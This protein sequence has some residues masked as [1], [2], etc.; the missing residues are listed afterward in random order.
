MPRSVVAN[1]G[2]LAQ[3]NADSCDLDKG[4]LAK[5]CSTRGVAHFFG[6]IFHMPDYKIVALGVVERRE[7]PGVPEGDEV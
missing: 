3:C 2:V 1:D 4:T 6:D 7:A 5:A